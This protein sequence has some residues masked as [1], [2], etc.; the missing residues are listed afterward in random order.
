[1]LNKVLGILAF[2][3]APWLFI[4]T[5]IEQRMP[6][7]YDSWFTGVWGLLFISGWMCATFALMRVRAA[8]N[9]ISGK[10]LLVALL[11]ALSIANISNVIQITAERNKPSYFMMLDMFWPLSNII[12]LIVGIKVILAR[13][14]QGWKRYVPLATGLWFPLAML[15]TVISNNMVSFWMGRFYSVIAWSLLAWIIISLSKESTAM[16][17]KHQAD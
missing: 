15:S 1:M 11:I 13:S 4:G 10:I 17:S 12:M 7:L 5:S 14:L 16:T 3:G 9:T 6:H 2:I 8:G